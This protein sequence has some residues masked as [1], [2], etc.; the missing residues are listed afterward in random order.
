MKRLAFAALFLS[1]VL[2]GLGFPLG[3]AA[4]REVDASQLVMLRFAFAGLVSLPFALGTREARALFRSPLAIA[5][6][7]IYALAFLVQFEGLARTRVSLAALIVGI[8]PALIA[9]GARL[10]GEPVSRLSWSGVAAA[11][12]GAALIAGR[13]AGG[14][15][16][17]GLVLDLAALLLFLTWLLLLRRV[18]RG[19]NPMCLPAVNV[20]V[21]AAVLLPLSLGLHG[22]PRLNLSPGAWAAIAGQG[23]F[24]TL[25]PTAAWQFGAARVGSATAGIFVNLE[26]LIGAVI[27]VTLFGDH[28]GVGLVAGGALIVAGS[29]VVVLG[30]RGTTAPDLAQVPATPT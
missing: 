19:P 11:S 7:V 3:K 1:G 28:L 10:L 27:G 25:I 6:G 14:A 13:P 16:P 12:I 29:L 2:W 24:C 20:I 15:T 21:A 30:E 5:T 9:V 22:A 4:L 17:F 26:P 23:V 8:M 18:P